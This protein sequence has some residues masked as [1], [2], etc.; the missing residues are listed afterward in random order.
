MTKDRNSGSTGNYSTGNFSTGDFSTG[1]RS[2]GDYSTGNRSTGDFS[3]GNFSTGNR[4]TGHFSSAPRSTGHF[5]TIAPK[6]SFF[7]VEVDMTWEE[8]AAL[9]PYVHVPLTEWV[10]SEGMTDAEKSEHP[11][12]AHTGGFLR[13]R[14]F[15]EAFPIAWSK[16]DGAT[17]QR[18]LD[19]P[20]FDAEKFLAITGVDVRESPATTVIVGDEVEATVGGRAVV[21]VVREVR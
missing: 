14:R 17:K 6:P 8:A 11:S 16:L 13:S 5:A 3:T 20:N 4:S 19:L 18:F 7:D 12:H 1:D 15:Q 9:I 2:T 10:A 21:M